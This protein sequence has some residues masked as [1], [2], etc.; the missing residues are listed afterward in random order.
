M[1][2]YLE[3]IKVKNF[4]TSSDGKSIQQTERNQLNRDLTSQLIKLLKS[5]LGEIDVLRTSNGIGIN[6]ENDYLG[7]IPIELKISVKSL[8]YDI[9]D[10]N[11]S[12]NAKQ[13]EKLKK[14]LQKQA[15]KQK[16]KTSEN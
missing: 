1:K 7:A 12:Y 11:E 6:L 14:E 3:K 9:I 13:K 10:E 15:K 2:N 4:K 5:Q 8:D 16:P